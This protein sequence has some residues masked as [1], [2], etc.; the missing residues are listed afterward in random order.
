MKTS[1]NTLS[2]KSASLLPTTVPSHFSPITR[3]AHTYQLQP[4]L[5]LFPGLYSHRTLQPRTSLFDPFSRLTASHMTDRTLSTAAFDHVASRIPHQPILSAPVIGA[6]FLH[7]RSARQIDSHSSVF[8]LRHEQSA[9]SR[10]EVTFASRTNALPLSSKEKSQEPGDKKTS[11]S[12][13]FS[14]EAAEAQSTTAIRSSDSTTKKPTM[15]MDYGQTQKV[16]QTADHA[17]PSP[18][19]KSTAPATTKAIVFDLAS[20]LSPETKTILRN[21]KQ[22]DNTTAVLLPIPVIQRL[23]QEITPYVSYQALMTIDDHLT[24]SNQDLIQTAKGIIQQVHQNVQISRS[25]AH[26]IE[27]QLLVLLAALQQPGKT[28]SVNAD[29]AD[30]LFDFSKLNLPHSEQRELEAILK[31]E[32]TQ[33]KAHINAPQHVLHS[34]LVNFVDQR[35][36]QAVAEYLK[37]PGPANFEEE[38]RVVGVTNTQTHT[39]SEGSG[40]DEYEETQ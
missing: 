11:E 32:Q 3:F 13:P 12:I 21:L 40:D 34:I 25:S 31:S 20:A 22:T 1:F 18:Q 17:I 23:E 36:R 16:E 10:S 38:D 9:F 27:N 29:E 33:L 8:P 39:D 14:Q 7:R 30:R 19:E 2:A 4:R 35:G 37:N 28:F 5:S 26:R 6:E 24:F 15:A